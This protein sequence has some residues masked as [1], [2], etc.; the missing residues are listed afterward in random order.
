MKNNKLIKMSVILIS[1]ILCC[2]I[3]ISSCVRKEKEKIYTPLTPVILENIYTPKY[4]IKFGSVKYN[5][6]GFVTYKFDEKFPPNKYLNDLNQFYKKKKWIPLNYDLMNALNKRGQ[7]RGWYYGKKNIANWEQYWVSHTG[8]AIDINITYQDK[9]DPETIVVAIGY[10]KP[11]I[12]NEPLQY[13]REIH[14]EKDEEPNRVVLDMIK[15]KGHF[16][17][18][19]VPTPEGNSVP[20]KIKV[21][22]ENLDFTKTGDTVIIIEQ[23]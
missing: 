20:E 19:L 18:V 15:K 4:A 7:L 1:I 14:G 22:Y 10:Y 16:I 5:Y 6:G 3:M 21:P 2:Y 8:E 17:F 23:N 12:A 11:E 9:S 13:Y